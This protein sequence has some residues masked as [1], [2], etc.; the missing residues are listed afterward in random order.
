MKDQIVN[1]VVPMNWSPSV[2]RLVFGISKEVQY[3]ISVWYLSYSLFCIYIDCF[4]LCLTH[5]G[6]GFN[7]P[8]VEIGVP[9]IVCEANVLWYDSMKFC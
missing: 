2:L 6:K 4:S 8:V 5:F 1:F 7:L 9:A 3:F